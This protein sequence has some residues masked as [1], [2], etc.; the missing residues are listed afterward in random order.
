MARSNVYAIQTQ[1]PDFSPFVIEAIFEADL[2]N[3]EEWAMKNNEFAPAVNR[4]MSRLT[5]SHKHE[6]DIDEL[7]E[8]LVNIPRGVPWP[9]EFVF[10]GRDE[11]YEY[12]PEGELAFV[13]IGVGKDGKVMR[14]V[15]E[16]FV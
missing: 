12:N 6:I 1:K 2:E 8:I 14:V 3:P 15:T 4:L 7:V 9:I 5:K 11:N 10:H 16:E 13:A